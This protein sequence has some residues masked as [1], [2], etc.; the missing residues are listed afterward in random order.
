MEAESSQGFL[1]YI[2]DLIRKKAHPDGSNAIAE[3]IQDLMD[4]GMAKGLVSD[5]ESHM[6]HGVLELRETQAHSIMVPRTEMS[7]APLNATL[8][9]VIHLVRECG[10]TRIPIFSGTIDKIEGILH[11]KDLLKL[12]GEAPE[13]TIPPD[14]L[15]PPF[16][17]PETKP[18]AEL[19][20]DLK[21]R[22]THMAVVTDEYGGTAGIITI[23][24]ILEEIVGEI[25]DEHD[26]DTPFLT[27]HE[28]GT[29]LVDAR[30][31]AEK[32]EEFL[33]FKLPKGDYESV[34]GF[35]IHLLGRIP[36]AGEKIPFEGVNFVIQKADQRK[37][38]EILI[39]P[40]PETAFA[41]RLKT[42]FN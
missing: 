27:V 22:Q 9:E 32:L 35:I 12:W 25:L 15:R 34:G 42:G 7:A 8:G 38:D 37:I 16:F 24:D 33:N 11:A 5:E 29:A 1:A 10:H 23:E 19:L 30:M 14:L 21:A 36:E 28:D 17:V 20:R 31:E 26:K 3:E 2:R 39:E 40:D 13:I 4:E 6:V 18:L 41:E